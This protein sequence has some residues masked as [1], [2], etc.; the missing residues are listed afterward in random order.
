MSKVFIPTLAHPLASV[1]NGD[2]LRISVVHA[3]AVNAVGGGGSRARSG[4]PCCL[5]FYRTAVFFPSDLSHQHFLSVLDDN[6]VD[7]VDF[8]GLSGEVVGCGGNG[9]FGN[10]AFLNTG[11]IV[12]IAAE[13]E[14]FHFGFALNELD[15][16]ELAP[17]FV[18]LVPVFKVGVNIE[19]GVSQNFFAEG[20]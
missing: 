6:A 9:A 12:V 19:R 4:I 3:L 2:T 1:L 7:I 18:A 20:C 13:A 16:L 14:T 8:C 11:N 5:E 17:V 10:E 15:V